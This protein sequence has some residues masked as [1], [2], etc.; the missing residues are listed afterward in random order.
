MCHVTDRDYQNTTRQRV[1]AII[2][3]L[4]VEYRLGVRQAGTTRMG[5]AESK[6]GEGVE[7]V[8][9][10]LAAIRA[11]EAHLIKHMQASF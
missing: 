3:I 10:Q 5:A 2:P 8:Q 6:S 1:D 11:Q 4:A 9:H 7:D